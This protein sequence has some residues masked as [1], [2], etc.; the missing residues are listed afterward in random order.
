MSGHF[1][2]EKMLQHYI[3]RGKLTLRWIINILRDL[4]SLDAAPSLPPMG[5]RRLRLI[6]SFLFLLARARGWSLVRYMLRWAETQTNLES[7]RKVLLCFFFSLGFL[8]RRISFVFLSL[9]GTM[10]CVKVFGCTSAILM[11]NCISWENTLNCGYW[12]CGYLKMYILWQTK[13][14]ICIEL[15]IHRC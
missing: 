2:S 8:F 1:S 7:E 3:R 11:L 6:V 13:K 15:L 4:A 10:D 12:I 14:L 9:H 5:C